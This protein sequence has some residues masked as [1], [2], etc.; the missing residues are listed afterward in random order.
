MFCYQPQFTPI[1]LVTNPTPSHRARGSTTEKWSRHTTTDKLGQTV[2]R[3]LSSCQA[4]C[5]FSYI[6]LW[7][8]WGKSV[9]IQQ[10]WKNICHFICWTL[11]R[12]PTKQSLCPNSDLERIWMKQYQQLTGICKVQRW[13]PD[14]PKAYDLI[15]CVRP[16]WTGSG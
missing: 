1:S 11:G 7:Q 8:A 4:K 13:L 5:F 9:I 6:W 10:Q 15:G 12:A 2:T 3:V 14:F 16:L